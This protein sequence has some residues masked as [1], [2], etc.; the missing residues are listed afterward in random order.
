MYH[1]ARI[2][3]ARPTYLNKPKDLEDDESKWYDAL[4]FLGTSLSDKVE[5]GPAL[6]LR[7]TILSNRINFVVDNWRKN[8]AELND[9]IIGQPDSAPPRVATL[10]RAPGD[11]PVPTYLHANRIPT[12][13]CPIEFIAAQRPQT[14]PVPKAAPNAAVKTMRSMSSALR[15]QLHAQVSAQAVEPT[16]NSITFWQT[17]LNEDVNVIVDLD[18][19]HAKP[20]D[21]PY[22]PLT[23]AEKN[24]D[25]HTLTLVRAEQMD[26]HLRSEQIEARDVNNPA[27]NILRLHYT[28]W[29]DGHV[30]EPDAL[31]GLADRVVAA[32]NQ[33]GAKVLVHSTHGVGRTGTLITFIAASQQIMDLPE[34]QRTMSSE[35][36]VHIVRDLVV[37]GRIER[38]PGFVDSSHINLIFIALLKKHFNGVTGHASD[39]NGELHLLK[40]P[41]E[42]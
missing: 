35:K 14:A 27:K 28:A 17:V 32:S 33:Q 36:L 2:L 4:K 8:N 40:Q 1:L 18:D 21:M 37:R 13:G 5:R 20:K 15:S 7:G 34:A 22:G 12:D 38:G 11:N 23:D 39:R 6:K 42:K 10:L 26:R 24:I 16:D 3:P 30:I 29:P 25:T 41:L 19:M 9:Q 31:I